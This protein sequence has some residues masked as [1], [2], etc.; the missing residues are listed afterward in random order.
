MHTS[1]TIPTLHVEGKDDLHVIANLL[2]QH[3]ID[4]TKT[5]R[6]IEIKHHADDD[7]QHGG[8]TV[9]IDLMAE[10][11]R[12]AT[13]RPVAF[14]IDIDRKVT[15]RWA[16]VAT[17]LKSA[18]LTPPDDCP[19]DG[20]IG[21]LPNYPYKAGVW[22]MPDCVSDHCKLEDLLSSLVPPNDPLWGHAKESTDQAQQ[23][24]AK[25]RDTDRTKAVV[26]CWLA[27]Q[28]DPGVPF[29]TAIKAKFFRHDSNEAKAFLRWIGKVYD[30]PLL[31]SL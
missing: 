18:G 16:S 1:G 4:M 23:H 15:D 21:Q 30:L 7:P 22:L 13:D 9:V 8:D 20:Y 2:E 28:K 11:I 25:Y 5:A 12:N 14:V 27:W 24:G 6:P 26:H 19:P 31:A 3:G 29:G 10:I 17:A